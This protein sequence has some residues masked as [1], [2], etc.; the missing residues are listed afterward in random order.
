MMVVPGL[1]GELANWNAPRRLQSLAAP[2]QAEAAVNAAPD[3][4]SVRSTVM[5]VFGG[6]GMILGVA[7]P[8]LSTTKS[9]TPLS[10]C[11]N[12]KTA[13]GSLATSSV[14]LTKSFVLEIVSGAR[15]FGPVGS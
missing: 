6:V 10:F 8:L 4:S 7:I 14:A 15:S 12:G 11:G 9:I 5:V 13:N 1:A 3:G 2:V